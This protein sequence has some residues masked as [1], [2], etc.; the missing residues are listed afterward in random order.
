MFLISRDSKGK[1]RVVDINCTFEDPCYV[2]TRSTYQYGGKI[3][4]QPD[5]AITKG[6][7]KRTMEEQADLELN[8]R[9]KSYLDKGYKQLPNDIESYTKNDLESLLPDETTDAQG[10][11][12]PMLAKDYH[13][14]A[15]SVLEKNWWYGSRKLDGVRCTMFLRDGEI[16]TSSRG[17]KDY[18]NSTSHITNNPELLKYFNDNPNLIL[19]GE[20][21]IHG[22]SLQQ[23]SGLARLKNDTDNC[24]KLQYFIYDIVDPNKIFVER[25]EMI[26]EF[27]RALQLGFDPDKEFNG[28]LQI[29]I[30]PHVKVEGWLDIKKLHDQYVSEGYEGLV[31]RNPD[32]KYGV[33]KRT[34]DMIKIKEY[35]EDEFEIID[36]KDGLRPE[37]M[38]FVL[39]AANGKTFEAKPVGPREL[40]HEYLKRM[41]EI[42]GKKATVKYFSLSDEGKPT[43]PVLKAIRDYE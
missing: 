15:T 1:I 30:L 22:Y 3:T 13:D 32:K 5:V 29:Q 43:Q 40:K 39:E 20:L 18:D 23:L 26:E 38:V 10:N 35:M 27:Q 21:Y 6:K 33:N 42:I 4:R 11:L 41:D 31:V 14:I 25:L 12:K 8:S 34:N 7:A 36:Y 37:D 17:G 28:E 24:N 16:H 19:D 9:I 2:I